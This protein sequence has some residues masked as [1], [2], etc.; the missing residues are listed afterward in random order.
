VA[1]SDLFSRRRRPEPEDD[2]RPGEPAHPT[3][4]LARFLASLRARPNPV[5]LDLGPVVGS[6]LTF[7]GEELGCKVFVED[8]FADIDRHAREGTAGDLAEFL[9]RRFPQDDASVDGI[10]CWD[11]LDYLDKKAV[12]AVARQLIRVLRPEGVLLAMFNATEPRE[13]DDSTFT[14]FVIV[15]PENLQYRQYP[16]VQRRGRTLQNRDIQ[17]MFEPLTISEQFLMKSHVREVLFRKPALPDSSAPAG[18]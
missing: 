8:L 9:A 6:N 15:D 12:A 14:R 17:R 16:A 13:T 18:S 3:K 7:F 11:A 2:L 10:L 1:L 5:L 4:A